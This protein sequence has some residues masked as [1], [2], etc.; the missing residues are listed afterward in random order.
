[1]LVHLA[2]LGVHHLSRLSSLAAADQESV[3]PWPRFPANKYVCINI[4]IARIEFEGT[5]CYIITIYT[6]HINI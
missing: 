6:I 5:I 1:M 4:T 3:G 2:T